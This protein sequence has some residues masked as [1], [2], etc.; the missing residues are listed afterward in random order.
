MDIDTTAIDVQNAEDMANA[1]EDEIDTIVLCEREIENTLIEFSVIYQGSLAPVRLFQTFR[2][3]GSVNGSKWIA[4]DTHETLQE[5][6]LDAVSY[7]PALERPDDAE[8]MRMESQI[9]DEASH[10]LMGKKVDKDQGV[11]AGMGDK[12]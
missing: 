7:V 5:A 11:F 6:I 8:V 2:R 12:S 9:M 10:K 4:P 1:A 3:N